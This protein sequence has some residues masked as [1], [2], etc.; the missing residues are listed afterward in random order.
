[1]DNQGKGKLIAKRIIKI[2]N[3]DFLTILFEKEI[4]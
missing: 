3:S 1:M 2:I 4:I